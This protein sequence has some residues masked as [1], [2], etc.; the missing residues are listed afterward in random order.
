MADGNHVYEDKVWLSGWWIQ[1][2]YDSLRADQSPDLR[3]E[4]IDR[5]YYHCKIFP[6][7]HCIKHYNEYIKAN[8]PENADSMFAYTWEFH[9]AVNVRLGKE[10]WKWDKYYKT[11]KVEGYK[12]KSCSTE[13]ERVA[14][15]PQENAKILPRQFIF[16]DD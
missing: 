11:Y 3:K 5:L 13:P 12:C 1:Y 14:S 8:K 16:E 4:F 2:H 6:C 10:A 15:S 9:N 7:E